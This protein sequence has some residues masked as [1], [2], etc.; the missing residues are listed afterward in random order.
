MSFITTYNIYNAMLCHVTYQSYNIYIKSYHV[1]SY[2]ISY[3][4]TSYHNINN[5]EA[6]VQNCE[7]LNF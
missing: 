6:C 2:I 5:S 1:M 7:Y 4:I 3:N